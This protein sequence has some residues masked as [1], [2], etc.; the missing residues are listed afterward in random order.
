MPDPQMNGNPGLGAWWF[1]SPLHGTYV[2]FQ[3]DGGSIPGGGGTSVVP[4]AG[5]LSSPT[6]TFLNTP[7]PFLQF[8]SW[9]EIESVDPVSYD[10]MEVVAVDVVTGATVVLKTLN[11]IAP[12]AGASPPLGTPSGGAGVGPLNSAPAWVMHRIFLLSSPAP[13]PLFATPAN[14]AGNPFRIE[15]RFDTVDTKYNGFMGWIVDE[16]RIFDAISAHSPSVSA[17]GPNPVFPQ[18]GGRVRG[19]PRP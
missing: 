5:V 8:K 15:F 11:P 16:V 6:V 10:I 9:F 3:F 17:G 2:G 1:G 14:P 12:Q 19:P 7:A 18:V 13:A 4:Q